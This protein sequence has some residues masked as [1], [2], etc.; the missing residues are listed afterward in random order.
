M[1]MRRGRGDLK[2]LGEK[3]KYRLAELRNHFFLS[4]I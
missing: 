2:N 4:L 1:E 3:R